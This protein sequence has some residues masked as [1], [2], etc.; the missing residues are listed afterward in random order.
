MFCISA[1]VANDEPLY[2]FNEPCAKV[3]GK[4]MSSAAGV[5]SNDVVASPSEPNVTS[6]VQ[7]TKSSIDL[8]I[9]FNLFS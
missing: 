5:E 9:L 3:Y 8:L 1:T 6:A 7:L 2:H 4:L